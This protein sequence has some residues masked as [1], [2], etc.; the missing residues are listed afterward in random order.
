[1][2]GLLRRAWLALVVTLVWL[3]ITGYAQG[4]T[5]NEPL[6]ARLVHQRVVTGAD[7][8]ERYMP[9][10]HA[11]PGDL[12]EYRATYANQ[13]Q[14][15]LSGVL[16]T[17]PIPAGMVYAPAD[18]TPKPVLASLDGVR[19]EPVPIKRMVRNPDG[20]KALKEVPLEEY[21]ALRWTLDAIRAGQA[22][23]VRARMRIKPTAPP[24]VA[25]TRA[26]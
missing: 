23:T 19:F 1:M 6:R 13:L 14:K 8:G 7:S 26:R 21:H 17:L 18:I 11:K 22:K 9:A 4:N 3:P 15:N 16:A 2:I 12:I 10:E 24:I 20:T 25:A 5:G